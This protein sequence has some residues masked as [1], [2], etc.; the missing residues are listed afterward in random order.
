MN[1]IC[2]YCQ[3]L[4]PAK[5]C[6]ACHQASYCT[7]DCQ[8]LDWKKHK[9]VCSKQQS[10][11]KTMRVCLVDG[12]KVSEESVSLEQKDLADRTIWHK[13]VVPTMLGVPLVVKRV[14]PSKEKQNREI[15]VFM[16]VDPV[17]GLAPLQWMSSAHQKLGVLMFART[18]GLD[19]N[20]NFF[21]TVYSYIYELMDLYGDGREDYVQKHKLNPLAFNDFKAKEEEMQRQC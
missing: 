6:S 12:A 5:R 21:W 10:D 1:S 9:L 2:D 8:K 20:S 16:M 11:T 13:C 19:L 3:K 18:D 17:T 14:G 4:N 7:I 15:A